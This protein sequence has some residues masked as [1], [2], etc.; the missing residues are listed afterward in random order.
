MAITEERIEDL[1][2]STVFTNSKH[3]ESL[4]SRLGSEV[5]EL[6]DAELEMVAGGVFVPQAYGSLFTDE[7]EN[8]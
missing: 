1:L 3:K 4:R 5:R 8:M 6:S 7:T 2:R